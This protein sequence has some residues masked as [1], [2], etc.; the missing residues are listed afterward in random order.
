MNTENW[1]QENTEYFDC[2]LFDVDLDDNEYKKPKQK[3]K[4]NSARRKIEMLQ[5]QKELKN[6][7]SDYFSDGW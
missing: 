7:I 6:E 1:Q 3:R 2:D 5:D 4:S